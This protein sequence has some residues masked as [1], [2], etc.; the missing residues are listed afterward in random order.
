[1]EFLIAATTD[2]GI[3][4]NVNQDALTVKTISAPTGKMAFALLCDGMGGLSAGEVASASVIRAFDLW[5]KNELPALCTGPLDA[6]ALFLQWTRLVQEQNET[7]RAYGEA[8]GFQLGTTAVA[9]LLTEQ[10]Y[11]LLNVGDSRI[12]ELSDT[13]SLLTHDQTLV[14]R[15]V[16]AGRLAPEAAESDPRRNVL[17]QCIGASEEVHPEIAAGDVKSGA[18]YLLCSDGFRHEINETELLGAL[19]PAV[20][21]DEATMHAGAVTLTELVKSRGENDNISVAMVQAR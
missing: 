7:I 15:E 13:L 20:A 5:V 4:K 16:A 14:A 12:Y 21:P 9:L 6:N 10:H 8:H 2:I 19:S 1:M 11:Y 18:T 3:A 17:L